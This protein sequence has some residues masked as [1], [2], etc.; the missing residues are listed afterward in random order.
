MSDKKIQIQNML[1]NNKINNIN[2]E[3][4]Q[5]LSLLHNKLDK[6]HINLPND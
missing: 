3:E 4:E 6:K 5:I 1:K 2:S